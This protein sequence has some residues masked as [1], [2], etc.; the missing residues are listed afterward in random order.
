MYV[1]MYVY[2]YVY[3]LRDFPI[4]IFF[5][6]E[7]Y[8]HFMMFDVIFMQNGIMMNKLKSFIVKMERYNIF[9]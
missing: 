3:I 7:E 6:V 4:F 2:V 8:K 9:W 5:K 1:C